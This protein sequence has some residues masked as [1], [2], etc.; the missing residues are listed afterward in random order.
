MDVLLDELVDLEALDHVNAVL[1]QQYLVDGRGE[2]RLGVRVDLYATGIRSDNHGILRCQPLSGFDTEPGL[3]TVVAIVVDFPE[4]PE[5]RVDD[6]GVTGLERQVLP[7]ER[8]LQV[9]YRYLVPP[10]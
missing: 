10:R 8:I 1:N 2:I 5:P 4:S 3:R 6:D 7:F 9:L